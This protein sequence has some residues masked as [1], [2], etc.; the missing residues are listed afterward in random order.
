MQPFVHTTAMVGLI[1]GIM[2]ML[3]LLNCRDEIQ[4]QPQYSTNFFT[5]VTQSAIPFNSSS[6][7]KV[8]WLYYPSD[9]ATAPSGNITKIYFRSA[10]SM[11]PVISD[12]TNFQVKMGHTSLSVLPPGPWITTNMITV[13]SAGS[14]QVWPLPGDWMAVTLQTPFPYNS[15]QNFIV[16]ASQGTYS[17]GF[18][19]M[20]ASL[21][22]RSL[23]G[24]TSSTLANSQNV[25]CDFGFDIALGTTDATLE[26]FPGL[27]DTLCSGIKPVT[28]IL[29]NNG[30]A[31]MSNVSIDWKVN[32]QQ[33]PPFNWT[34]N[35]GVNSTAQV[36][37]GQ[38]NFQPSSNTQIVA[39][40]S[41]PNLQP[42]NNPLND[43]I[44]KGN[45]VVVA[46]P[47]ATP[48]ATSYMIC[49]G[50][51]VWIGGSLTGIPPWSVVLSD[52]SANYSFTNLMTPSYGQYFSPP[53]TKSYSV[54]SITDASGCP[55]SGSVS[56]IVI[57][58]PQPAVSL[59]SDQVLKLSEIITLDAG[60]GHTTYQWSTG[61]TTQTIQI[62]G[63]A[64]APGTYPFV[65]TVTNNYNCAAIDT[66]W[67]TFVDDTGIELAAISDSFSIVPNPGDGKIEVI[68]HH[69]ISG[70]LNITIYA[71]DGQMIFR[72]SLYL[73]FGFQSIPL[74]LSHLTSGVY[75]ICL[76]SQDK[77][78]NSRL[79]I[80]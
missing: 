31:S 68:I 30:P 58:N 39:W 10:P 75:L 22:A 61:A 78:F 56:S 72:N 27:S 33:Q 62:A 67:I 14:F 3:T 15:T 36:T 12:F 66:V 29:K 23:Y 17:V 59:G 26:E 48:S 57:V 63:S 55:S 52:G 77:V 35:L 9:F 6:Y 60:S 8:Q 20:Q 11:L 43:T 79:I 25:L 21:T 64:Y 74:D 69:R 41:N 5:S 40:T 32:N 38:Y 71:L 16:E 54:I 47:S 70:H 50:D 37:I 42:D 24:H 7:N 73:T 44:A 53:T 76:E 45:L 65:V 80:R 28:V 2:L 51:S 4:A 19:V 1:K 18:Y 49:S 46:A 13:F 34:G